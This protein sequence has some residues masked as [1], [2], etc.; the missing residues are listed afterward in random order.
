MTRDLH[1]WFSG[2]FTG[3]AVLSGLQTLLSPE[4]RLIILGGASLMLFTAALTA[5]T[6][7]DVKK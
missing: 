4:P 7:P 6:A 2:M 5:L 3:C 1:F